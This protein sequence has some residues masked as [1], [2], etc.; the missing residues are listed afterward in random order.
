VIELIA[1]GDASD[2][3]IDNE[4][5]S[6]SKP[7]NR[8]ALLAMKAM[9]DA[10]LSRMDVDEKDEEKVELTQKRIKLSHTPSPEEDPED[11]EMLL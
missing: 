1:R 10:K 6:L 7:N 8:V 5:S 2:L 11:V 3:A 9:I 4:S